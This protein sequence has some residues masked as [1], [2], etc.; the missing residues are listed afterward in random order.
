MDNMHFEVNSEISVDEY[1]ALIRSTPLGDRRPFDDLHRIEGMLK[2]ANLLVTV[3]LGHRL[4]G[5]ARAITDFIWV[6][7]ISDLA[8][9]PNFQ[10]AG[11]GKKL[12]LKLRNELSS[13][14]KLLLLA[15]PFAVDYYPHIGFVKEDRGWVLPPGLDI[16]K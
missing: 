10:R 2:N 15:A 13:E 16:N 4:V 7:Y 6:T 12:I 11:L 8:V 9:N 14:C 5:I 3:R 1:V